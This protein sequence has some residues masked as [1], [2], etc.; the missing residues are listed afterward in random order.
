[1]NITETNINLDVSYSDNSH[2]FG[3]PIEIWEE[4]SGSMGIPVL[5]E[6]GRRSLEGLGEWIE[7]VRFLEKAGIEMHL[8]Y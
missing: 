5:D 3:R 4:A 6:N 1:M 2:I 8:H 7:K